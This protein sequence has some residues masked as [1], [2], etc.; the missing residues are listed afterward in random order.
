MIVTR[1]IRIVICEIIMHMIFYGFGFDFKAA[2]AVIT[3]ISLTIVIECISFDIGQM[4][5]L[6]LQ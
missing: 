4:Q 2:L 5:Y 3:T 6:V 1:L